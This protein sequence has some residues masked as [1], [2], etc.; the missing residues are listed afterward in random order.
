MLK[1]GIEKGIMENNVICIKWGT[2][3]GAEYVNKLYKMVE[4]NLT[5]PHRFVCFTDNAQGIVDGVEVRPLPEL[6]DN[7]IPDRCWKKL[8]LFTDKLADLKGR[9]LFLDLDIVILKNID[10]L[11][12]VDGDFRIMKDPDFPNDIIGNSSVFRFDVNKYP[13]VIENFYKE[14]KDIRKKYKNEQAFLSHKMNDKGILKYWDEGWCLSFKR[15][16]LQPFPLNFFKVAKEPKDAKI[17]IFHGRPT[18]EEARKGY[19]GKGGLRY[20]KPVKWLDKYWS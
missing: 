10:E 5:V 16:C 2:K 1:H 18:P 4:K 20:V 19:F 8:G 3:F 6:D 12:K 13:D 17:L 7:G 14:G 15:H 9:A 11:F